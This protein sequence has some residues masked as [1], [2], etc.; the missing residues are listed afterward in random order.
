M[1]ETIP[2]IFGHMERMFDELKNRAAFDTSGKV[3]FVGSKVEAFRAIG[4]SQGYYTKIFDALVEM[5]C[6]EQVQRGAGNQPSVI[7]LHKRP[8]LDEYQGMYRSRLTRPTEL[9]ILRQ[10]FKDLQRRFQGIDLN[11]M[12]LSLNQRLEQLEARLD[13]L[14][15]GG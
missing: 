3:K 15:K 14:E 8:T 12:L 2:A 6:I 10:Q 4:V 1:T 11:S 7:L 13:K 5:G 9:D